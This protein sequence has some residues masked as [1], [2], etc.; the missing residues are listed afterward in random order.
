[1]KFPYGNIEHEGREAPGFAL[2][3]R[4][5]GRVK[6]SQNGF[7]FNLEKEKCFFLSFSKEKG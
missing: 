1:M 4:S 3:N 6:G 2:L 5:R 7:A